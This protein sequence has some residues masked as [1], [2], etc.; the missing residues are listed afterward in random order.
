[1]GK[2]YRIRYNLHWQKSLRQGKR[3]RVGPWVLVVQRVTAG[4]H[5]PSLSSPPRT[6][7]YHSFIVFIG[8]PSAPVCRLFLVNR[9]TGNMPFEDRTARQ[10]WALH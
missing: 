5:A 9:Y 6:D 8:L 3:T 10:N 1:M 2:N 4:A 7:S